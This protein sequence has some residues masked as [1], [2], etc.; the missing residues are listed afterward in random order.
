[1]TL[2]TLQIDVWKPASEE[3]QLKALILLAGLPSRAPDDEGTHK[4]AY[5]LALQGVTRYGLQEAVKSILQGALGHAFFPSPPELRIQC[6]KAMEHHVSMRNRIARQE[7][8]RRERPPEP[9]PLTADAKERQRQRMAAFH[10]S[11]DS[12]KSA[13]EAAKL[14]AERAEIRAR[15]GMTPEVLASM[16]DQPLPEGMAQLSDIKP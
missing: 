4:A 13:E 14:E 7:Q 8:I 1:M 16:K 3:D 2:P 6:D 5:F 9:P 10:A 15:Y 12:G 11:L